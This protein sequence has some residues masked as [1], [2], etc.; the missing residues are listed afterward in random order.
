MVTRIRNYAALMPAALLLAACA[1]A[2]SLERDV[3]GSAPAGRPP[4]TPIVVSG[5]RVAAPVGTDWQVAR[6]TATT[7]VF[8]R[9]GSHPEHR[10]AAWLQAVRSPQPIDGY[11]QLARVVERLS[12]PRESGRFRDT[13]E[14]VDAIDSTR[15]RCLSRAS[16]IADFGA[17]P[18]AAAPRHIVAARDYFCRHPSDP[19]LLVLVHVSERDSPGATFATLTATATQFFSGIEF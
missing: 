8:S 15:V 17:P 7:V 1:T 19:R 12:R 13:F 4:G 16:R 9:P 11:F 6:Q 14:A 18:G 3:A 10:W 5:L 2:P